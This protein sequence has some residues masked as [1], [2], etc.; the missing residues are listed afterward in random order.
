MAT[1]GH[2]ASFKITRPFCLIREEIDEMLVTYERVPGIVHRINK[3][4]EQ[5]LWHLSAQ[6]PDPIELLQEIRC[7]LTDTEDHYYPKE[8]DGKDFPDA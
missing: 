3:G 6:N 8:S 2:P 4:I 7:W 1:D 5:Y